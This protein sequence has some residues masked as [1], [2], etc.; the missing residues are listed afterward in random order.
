MSRFSVIRGLEAIII[1]LTPIV[2]CD[3]VMADG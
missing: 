2:G 3:L 1:G